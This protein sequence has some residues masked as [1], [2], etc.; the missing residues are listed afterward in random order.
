MQERNP[1]RNSQWAMECIDTLFRNGT[2]CDNREYDIC[3]VAIYCAKFAFWLLGL[4]HCS[5]LPKV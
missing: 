3:M 5:F 4:I 1:T 2:L